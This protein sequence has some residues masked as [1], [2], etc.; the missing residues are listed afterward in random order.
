MDVVI[1]N[2]HYLRVIIGSLTMLHK[3]MVEVVMVLLVLVMDT[4]L[5]PTVVYVRVIMVHLVVVMVT[6]RSKVWSRFRKLLIL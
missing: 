6:S 1:H 5:I 2:M 3:E 4:T